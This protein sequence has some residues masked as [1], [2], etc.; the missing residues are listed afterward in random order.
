MILDTIVARKKEEVS[1]LKRTGINLPEQY[2]DWVADQPRG[3]RN[4]LTNFPGVSII[5]Y[6]NLLYTP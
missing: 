5:S 2:R 6:H 3:F 4:A 1:D